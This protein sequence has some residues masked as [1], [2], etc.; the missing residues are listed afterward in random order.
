[1]NIRF[2][3]LPMVL[4]AFAAGRVEA[5][6]FGV[7]VFNNLMPASGGMAG[8]SIASPQ[9]LQ[10]AINGNPA[11]LTQYRGTQFGL[12]G[13]WVEPTY[14]IS[15]AQPGLPFVGPYDAKSDA[16]GIAAPN[17]GVT[18]DFSA[19][20]LPVTAGL[21]LMAGSGAGVDFREVPASN[22]TYAS[23]VALDIIAGAGVC[24]TERLSLGS[25]IILSNATMGGPFVA[26]SGSSIDYGLRGSVGADYQLTPDTNLGVYWKSKASYTFENLVTFPNNAPGV[27]FDV[28][29]DRP[30][31]VG[32]GVSN[33]SLMDG[34]LLL[35]VDA[36]FQEY[37][38]TELFGE[39]F[40]NQ[41]AVQFGSQ[42]ALT[43]RVRLRL[44]YA[45]NQNPMRDS[46]GDRLGGLLP[47]GGVAQVQYTEALFAAIPQDRITGGVSLIDVLP[48]VDMDLLAGGMFEKSQTF[49]ITTASV[50]SYWVGAGFTWRFG[51]GSCGEECACE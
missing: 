27:Y 46:V 24:L 18:Q 3:V 39:L 10:S 21:G 33:K 30:Q 14:N 4:V 35:A 44:G 8:A 40:K 23:L 41:W 2:A 42:Y 50:E 1:M 13:A 20:D 25:S 31:C 34:R 38:G 9:D 11:A 51:R 48:G 43:D 37:S 17:I 16:Q 28:K 47:P 45:W 22:G 36:V 12:G 32:L 15:V 5:Q 19:W 26:N 29:A 49:G 7:E 6:S